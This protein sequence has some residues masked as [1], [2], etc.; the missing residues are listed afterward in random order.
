MAC[1]R[2]QLFPN[3]VVPFGMKAS[4]HGRPH[5]LLEP[6]GVDEDGCVEAP[7]PRMRR[8]ER[9]SRRSARDWNR[10]WRAEEH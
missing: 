5:V 3:N 2:I 10:Y 1:V 9:L 6:G 4:A 8:R 7:P